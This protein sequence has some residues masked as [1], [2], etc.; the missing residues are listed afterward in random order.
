MIP[1][2]DGG[3]NRDIL[4]GG[5]M[6]SF[7][8]EGIEEFQVASHQFSASDGRTGGSAVNVLTKSGTNTLKGSGFFLDRDQ[9]LTAKGY[10]TARDN[11]PK[12]P[13]NRRQFGGSLGGPILRNRAFFFVAAE[14]IREDT[15][16]AV[17]DNL[18]SELQLL[19]PFGM[20]FIAVRRS[21]RD[22]ARR[23]GR[24]SALGARAGV[25]RPATDALP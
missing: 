2:V 23:T 20:D 4:V 18:Y 5:P 24:R 1:V 15:S 14:G 17:P 3:D 9:A 11:K 12:L 21:P 16:I 13:Y 10:F 6:M 22:G 19:A 25:V 8:V 7:T